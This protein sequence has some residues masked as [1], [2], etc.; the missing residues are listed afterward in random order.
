MLAGRRH[1]AEELTE[2]ADHAGAE[3][4]YREILAARLRLDGPDYRANA[5]RQERRRPRT[6]TFSL[7]CSGHSAL[8]TRTRRKSPS[9]STA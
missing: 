1:L 3:A 7:T 4:E 2:Q 9:G 5:E 8:T 6:A